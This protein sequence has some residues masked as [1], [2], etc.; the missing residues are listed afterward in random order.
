MYALLKK[1][2]INVKATEKNDLGQKDVAFKNNAPFR[3]CIIKINSTLIDNAEHLSIVM[4]MY[5]S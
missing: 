1:E 2:K 3:S 5:N 4:L